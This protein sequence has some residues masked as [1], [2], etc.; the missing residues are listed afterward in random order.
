MVVNILYNANR[1]LRK[2]RKLLKIKFSTQ[3]SVINAKYLMCIK[4]LISLSS[5]KAQY[6][7]CTQLYSHTKRCSII[8]LIFPCDM[9]SNQYL[10]H[11]EL[12]RPWRSN[13]CVLLY[14]GS[15]INMIKLHQD[16]TLIL[17]KAHTQAVK[18]AKWMANTSQMSAF[19]FLDTTISNSV[20]FSVNIQSTA[21]VWSK[22]SSL[23]RAA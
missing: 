22:N 23:L 10:L 11:K 12:L 3:K 13:T 19:V 2:E 1:G 20:C 6:V 4:S 9:M 18:K 17:C 8:F 14:T 16:W 21:A 5:L 7:R 15:Y